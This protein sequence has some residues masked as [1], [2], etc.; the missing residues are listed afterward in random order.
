MQQIADRPLLG[1][2]CPVTSRPGVRAYAIFHSRLRL[3]RDQRVAT[4]AHQLIYRV[5]DDAVVEI[6]AIVGDSY[7][8]ARVT[9]PR[10]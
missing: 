2:S 10:R 9:I 6:L 1:G 4:P 5:A 7:P 3:P 8:A